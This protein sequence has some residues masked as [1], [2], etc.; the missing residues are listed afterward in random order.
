MKEGGGYD[1]MCNAREGISMD[2]RMTGI[3]PF[4]GKVTTLSRQDDGFDG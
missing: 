4:C 3:W 1:F 2:G